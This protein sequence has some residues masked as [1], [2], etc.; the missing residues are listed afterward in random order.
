MYSVTPSPDNLNYIHMHVTSSPD[1]LNYV[2]TYVC[3][4]PF[5]WQEVYECTNN[6]HWKGPIHTHKVTNG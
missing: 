1:T 3:M 2:R 4:Q 6:G 5:T